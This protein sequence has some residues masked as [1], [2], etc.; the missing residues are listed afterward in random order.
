MPYISCLPARLSIHTDSRVLLK[1]P[2]IAVKKGGSFG[3]GGVACI[4]IVVS[5]DLQ[6]GISKILGRASIIT[7]T[8][9]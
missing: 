9:D 5:N 3:Y 7:G 1:L 8:I 4:E 6:N 2:H